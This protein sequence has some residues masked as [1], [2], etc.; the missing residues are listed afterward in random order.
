[1][2]EL[3]SALIMLGVGYAYF[4]EGML[5]ALTTLVN[6]F[7]AGLVAFNFYEPLSETLEN[8]FVNSP[9]NNYED[10]LS[11]FGLF[12]ATFA[13]LRGITNNLAIG[14]IEFHALAQQI[15]AT[16]FGVLA[17]YLLAGFLL[18]MMQTLP[19]DQKF[20]GFRSYVDDPPVAF[21]S[22]LP[23]DRVWLALMHRA[24]IG[25][26]KQEDSTTFDPEGTFE[27]RYEHKRR[28]KESQQEAPRPPPAQ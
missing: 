26:F 19:W 2:L 25:P 9:L 16:G 20:L 15:C 6:V 4:R 28:L 13:L 10:A 24:G 14:E 27:L 5:T 7:I 22:L 21:R 3:M 18:C 17:G 23:P 8:T 11:L 1:M 12:I